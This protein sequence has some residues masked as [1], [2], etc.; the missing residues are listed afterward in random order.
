MNS[1]CA[2]QLRQVIPFRD[3]N[4]KPISCTTVESKKK[5]NLFLYC[6]V[7][8]LEKKCKSVISRCNALRLLRTGC[9]YA[10][11]AGASCHRESE[12]VVNDCKPSTLYSYITAVW[13][14]ACSLITLKCAEWTWAAC[15]LMSF[16]SRSI[17]ASKSEGSGGWVSSS[18]WASL[19]STTKAQNTQWFVYHGSIMVLFASWWKCICVVCGQ[20]MHYRYFRLLLFLLQLARYLTANIPVCVGIFHLTLAQCNIFQLCTVSVSLCWWA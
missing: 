17:A 16:S 10:K 18:P 12:T 15:L 3:P 13:S 14:V 8:L 7:G 20:H 9:M 5:F 6:I 2:F 19:P 4:S 1:L 11:T